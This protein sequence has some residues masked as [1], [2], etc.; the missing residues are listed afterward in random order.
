MM[1]VSQLATAARNAL[2][3][4]GRYS[5]QTV[6]DAI[7]GTLKVASGKHPREAYA[8]FFSD[9]TAVWRRLTPAGRKRVNK[10]LAQYPEEKARMFSAPVHDIMIG[11]KLSKVVMFL[12]RGQEYFFRKMS[13]D[14]KFTS[15]MKQAGL[16]PVRDKATQTILEQATKNSLELTFADS[17]RSQAGKALLGLYDKVPFLTTVNPYPRFWLNSMKF[18]WDFNPTGYL[19][20]A[21]RARMFSKNPEMVYEALSKATVGTIMLGMAMEFRDSK[22][23]GEKYYEIKYGE[24]PKTGKA[25]YIDTR[26]FAPFS[27]YLYLAEQIKHPE[28]IKAQDRIQ[29]LIG[30]NRIGGTGLVLIDVLRN[31]RAD[32]ARKMLKEFVGQWLGGFTVPARSVEDIIGQW[33]KEARTVRATREEPL[34]GPAR[35]NIPGIA[36]RMKP[37]PR[38]TRKE[39][40]K[41]EA[42]LMRQLTGLTKKT[43]TKL[44]REMDRTRVRGVWPRTGDP[45]FDRLMTQGMGPIVEN[46]LG[47]LVESQKYKQASDEDKKDLLQDSFSAVKQIV[48]S[49]LHLP[50]VQSQLRTKKP[51]DKAKYLKH[52]LER[53]KLSQAE[54]LVLA[55]EHEELFTP[56][57]VN[58]LR[59]KKTKLQ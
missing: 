37:A 16:D 3:Q 35:Q 31:E 23:A 8:D 57:M 6:D 40:Y 53:N 27:T 45:K 33:N 54:I 24:D 42:T 47:R 13:F 56:E 15:L 10:I 19:T 34:L 51:K 28:R 12:N 11:D 9:F 22:Y 20:A 32:T 2:S 25:K 55:K 14:A 26:A 7:R 5:I 29:G 4:A 38:L 17:A 52:L 44:E 30:I 43:K 41:R 58:I 49:Q 50:Y 48:R 46:V 18:L 39:P 36:G 1:M 21:S 59:R